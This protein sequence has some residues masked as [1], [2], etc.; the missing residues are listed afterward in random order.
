M[1]A[2]KI[3]IIGPSWI[4]DMVM[5]Q[6]LFR[7]LKQQNESTLIDV[8]APAWSEPLI[9]RM[10][11]VRRSIDMPFAHGQ[12]KPIKRLQ[13]GA[14]LISEKYDQAIVLP[15]TWKAALLPF[16]AKI[17]K[18]TGFV[19]EARWG[20][21]NDARPLD[22][23]KLP[24]MVQRHVSLGFDKDVFTDQRFPKP[25]LKTSE[26][27]QQAVLIKLDLPALT[28]HI[29]VFCP[30]AEYGPAKRWPA[31]H[32]A[33][34]AL[35]LSAEGKTIWL[36]GSEKDSAI[37]HEI[38]ELTGNKCDDLT[39]RT[40]LEDVIDLLAM[41]S[42]V[43]CNDSGLMH[44]AAAVGA[45]IVALYGSSDPGYTPPLADNV[46]IASLKLDCSPCFKKECPLGHYDC[47][48][49]LLVD[50]IQ[51]DIEFSLRRCR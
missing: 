49:N 9:A 18:R 33:T 37:A 7:H 10:P 26:K 13:M 39:G 35:K 21:L 11:E 8:V 42:L 20:L 38:N 29:V 3:L 30:G 23:N 1:T 22:K 31:K 43:V 48:N 5:A 14:R 17:T 45:P 36:L 2:F 16:G 47:L 6:S 40:S 32:F 34:L 44:I 28:Q 12:F 51:R 41:A 25:K 50:R 24:M 4:G 19:G 27:L 46:Q 15:Y